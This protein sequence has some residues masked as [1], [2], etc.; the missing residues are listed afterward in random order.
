MSEDEIKKEELHDGV[1]IVRGPGFDKKYVTRA[2]PFFTEFD[3]RITISNEMIDTG[4][5]W[6]MVADEMIILTPTSAKELLE[7]LGDVIK[8]YEEVNGPIK[9]RP[10]KR[11][12]TTY[13]R[14]E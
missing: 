1:P 3:V 11:L 7:E 4:E 2:I 10:K 12:L 14:Q 8:A 5:V 6:A 9:D 13:T